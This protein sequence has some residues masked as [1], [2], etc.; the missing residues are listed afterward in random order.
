M[1]LLHDTSNYG[2]QIRDGIYDAARSGIVPMNVLRKMLR[3]IDMPKEFWGDILRMCNYR[4]YERTT[5][6]IEEIMHQLVCN[7][8]VKELL[9]NHH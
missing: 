2:C 3:K 6:P 5:D 4:R 1:E 7:G 8:I 9:T